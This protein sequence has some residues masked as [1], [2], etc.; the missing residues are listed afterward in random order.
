MSDVVL[1]TG[2]TGQVG[3]ELRRALAPLARVVAVDRQQCD[4]ASPDSI[5]DCIASVRPSFIVNAGAY[6]AVD[7]AESEPE[8]AHAVNAVAP[9]VLAEEA[10]RL[11]AA[12]VHYSTDYVFN[13]E[14]ERPY[15]ET[16]ATGPLGVY[17]ASKLQGEQE[18]A[19]VGGE[20][21]IFR[22]SWV[23]GLHGKNFLKTMLRLARERDALS[24]VADQYGAPTSA[25]LI[26]DVT[27]LL[28][29]ESRLGRGIAPGLYHLAA[30][31]STSWHEYAQRVISRAAAGG[32]AL[33]VKAESIAAISSSAYPTPARR[34]HNS[35][36]DC[37]RL[38][39]ALGITLPD[40]T[41]AVDQATDILTEKQ[42]L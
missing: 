36:L 24:V 28:L 5:R 21:W 41:L 16:D 7:K 19:A 30:A 22:T 40:W 18:I 9:R 31:G 10:A 25:A 33:K 34:P 27:A 23:F 26:A 4:L 20:H 8:L 3:F 38:Q 12:L 11:N 29:R 1:V 42:F 2:C 32:S 39:E 15:A 37:A 13:G 35:R 17:G 14:G 6:T